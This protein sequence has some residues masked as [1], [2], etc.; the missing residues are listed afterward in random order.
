MLRSNSNILPQVK[1]QLLKNYSRLSHTWT[2]K[3]CTN[4]LSSNASAEIKPTRFHAF[5]GEVYMAVPQLFFL[6]SFSMK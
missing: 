6:D 3:I 5:F 2:R 4:P 1:I